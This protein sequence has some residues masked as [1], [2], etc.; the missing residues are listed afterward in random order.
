MEYQEIVLSGSLL[1]SFFVVFF[2]GKIVNDVFNQSYN[3]NEELVEK[4]NAALALA[5]VGYYGGLVLTIG[6]TLVGESN[7]LRADLQDLFVY[8][9]TGIFLLNISWVICDKLLFPHFKMNDELIRDQNKGAGAIVGGTSLASG[10]ILFGAI[11]GE[12]SPLTLLSFWAIGQVLLIVATRLYDLITP[13]SIHTEIEKDNVAVGISTGGMLTA[14]G[15]V[16]GLAAEGDFVDW[17]ESLTQF[18]GYAA[19]GLVL[20]PVIRI[21]ADKVLLPGASLTDELVNQEKPNTGAAYIEAFSYIA[22]SFA[23]YWCV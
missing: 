23:I 2:I 9:I 12:G 13:Y 5:L 8:G 19:L 10:F 16:I 22:T 7:G 1:I 20:I 3:L 17:Q 11:Q 21:I 14:I 4:D 18:V 15:I 6:G